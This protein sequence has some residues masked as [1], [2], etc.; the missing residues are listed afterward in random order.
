MNIEMVQARIK[1]I[2]AEMDQTKANYNKLEGHLAES[3]YLLGILVGESVKDDPLDKEHQEQVNGE[4]NE[5]IQEQ[6]A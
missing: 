1:L 2:I 5:Q 4:I 6:I 3:N